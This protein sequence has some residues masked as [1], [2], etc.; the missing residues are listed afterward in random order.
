M[1]LTRVEK[2]LLILDFAK[3]SIQNFWQKICG[4]KVLKASA[5]LAIFFLLS[6]IAV[7]SYKPQ[8]NSLPSCS[9]LGTG[10][11]PQ[12]GVNCLINCS[13]LDSTTTPLPGQNCLYFGRPLCNTITAPNIPQH[14]VNCADLIDLPLCSDIVTGPGISVKPGKNCV[15]LCSNSAYDNPSPL[16]HPDWIRSVDY[17]IFNRDCIRFCDSVEDGIV[18]EPGVN[19]AERKCHQLV[20]DVAPNPSVNCNIL[21]CNLLTPDELNKA[22]FDDSAKQYCDGAGLKCY[23]FTSSQLPYMRLRQ[24]NPTCIIH[25]CPPTTPTCGANDVLNITN[26]NAVDP[27]YSSIYSQYIYGG[28]DLSSNTFCTSLNC[29]PVAKTQY[30]CTSKI[31]ATKTQ[32]LGYE[33]G[34]ITSI[35]GDDT[36]K[37]LNPN[38]DAT[39]GGHICSGNYCYK[40]VDCNV[41]ANSQASECLVASNLASDN[42]GDNYDPFDSWF[43]RPKPMSKATNPATGILLEMQEDLCYTENQMI[44]QKWGF[45][46]VIDWGILGSWD[47]GWFQNSWTN[48]RSPGACNTN[49]DGDRGTG[50]TYMCG[51]S[52]LLYN[53]PSQDAVYFK[54]YAVTDFS[55]AVPKHKVTV[56]TRFKNTLSLDTCGKRECGISELFSDF[57]SQAC[58]GDVCRELVI[59]ETDETACSMSDGLS[60]GSPD[61]CSATFDDYLRVRAV[62]YNNKICAFFDSKG[63]LAYNNMFF[64]GTE[65]IDF[66]DDDEINPGLACANDPAGVVTT[67]EGITT[68]NCDGYNSNSH[69][70]FADRWRAL[71]RVHYVDD[72]RPAN[73]PLGLKGY[74][75]RSGRLYSAQTCPKVTLRIPPPDLYNIGTVSNSEK[76]FAPPVIIRN[77]TKRRGAEDAIIPAGQVYGKTDFHFPEMKVMFGA[78]VYKMSLGFG[79]TGYE[80]S[81]HS[82][83]CGGATDAACATSPSS[84]T[85]TTN[86]G[87]KDYEARLFVRKEFF[88]LGDNTPQFCLYRRIKDQ[89]GLEITPLKIGCV[90]RND[91]D[92]NNSMDRAAD[93]SLPVRRVIIYPDPANQYN[94]SKINLRFLDG[95]TN[96]I[97]NNCA[98]DDKCTAEISLANADYEKPTCIQGIDKNNLETERQ[99]ICVQRE[100]CSAIYIDC[101]QNEIDLNNAKSSGQSLDVF[102]SKRSQCNGNLVQKCNAKK[103]IVA[104]GG[105]IFNPIP[106]NAVADPNAYGWFNEICIVSGF[107]PKLKKVIAHNFGNGGLGKCFIDQTS[108][109]LTDGN[110]ATNCNDGGR[111]PNCLCAVAPKDYITNIGEVVRLQTPHEAGLCVDMP[112]PSSC[113]AIDYNPNPNPDATDPE[114]INKSLG[115]SIY[116]DLTGIYH[117]HKDR[118]N[119]NIS[120]F[121]EFVQALP[122]MND[123][124]GVCSGFWTYNKNSFGVVQYPLQNCLNN[125][126]VASWDSANVKNPCIRYSCPDVLTAGPDVFGIYQGGYGVLES[127]EAKGTSNGFATWY[128]YTKTNDFLETT[129]AVGC[130]PGFKPKGSVAIKSVNGVITGYSGGTLPTRSCDQMGNWLLP[131]NACERIYCPPINSTNTPNPSSAQD[132]SGWTKWFV[133]GGAYFDASPIG[134]MASRS[135]VRAQTESIAT[136]R[137][138]T[139]IGFYQAGSPPTRECDYLGN[140]KEVKNSCSTSCTAVSSDD[141]GSSLNNGF[142]KWNVIKQEAILYENCGYDGWNIHLAVGDIADITRY[143]ASSIQFTGGTKATL[144]AGLNFSGTSADL[145]SDNSCFNNVNGID[146]ND[147]VQSIKISS[148]SGSS[149]AG[150]F[151]GCVAGYVTNP[152]PPAVDANGSPLAP[153]IANNLSRAPEN[154]KRA[155]NAVNGSAY[156][157]W[158]G[159]SNP[160]IDQ[161]PGAEVDSRIGV[162][163]TTHPLKSSLNGTTNISW[164]ST[165]LGQYAYVTNWNGQE[166]LFNAVYFQ[167]TSLVP[168]TNG[169][170]LMRRFCNN[171]GKWSDPEPLC[172]TNDGQI[173][174]AKYF[175]ANSPAGYKNSIAVGGAET[176]RGYCVSD[177][178]WNSNHGTGA[179]PQKKCSY[180]DSNNHIDRVYLDFA[181]NTKDCELKTCPSYAGWTGTRGKISPANFSA[182]DPRFVAGSGQISGSC[183]NNAKNSDDKTVYTSL[184]AGGTLP[185]INCQADGTWS[186]P[187]DASCK[188]GCDVSGPGKR[189]VNKSGCGDGMWYTL[190]DMTLAHDQLFNM[191]AYNLCDD[192]CQSWSY[193]VKCNDGVASVLVDR[194]DVD[195]NYKCR[196]YS[197]A[198]NFSL[199]KSGSDI[200]FSGFRPG[201]GDDTWRCS[202]DCSP[203]G[204]KDCKGSSKYYVDK[205][206]NPL[207]VCMWS[208]D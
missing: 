126:G 77:V 28:Q 153:A 113:L 170:Y 176:V 40:T 2:I 82:E 111:A 45:H 46:W 206:N 42:G 169:Y 57:T 92:I 165:P 35:K 15:D 38:C 20:G 66:N 128:K 150:Q 114:Y 189:R 203:V 202:G 207:S 52:G 30:R 64:D 48:L 162:G 160:C 79:Y 188:Y 60:N 154:P 88:P 27:S 94:N 145:T 159:V 32:Q 116:N 200:N 172:S 190:Q 117:T 167:A 78:Q 141:E 146:F 164:K 51:T 163:V 122:G 11:V 98:G 134:T 31:D 112:T 86:V 149:L 50:Y 69:E 1:K 22:K 132:S 175:D 97:D 85:V 54:G 191:S 137:C 14:R 118:S 129:K 68:I 3:E 73:T 138:N 71:L 185:H 109:Y 161:C 87:G 181:N 83:V 91:P 33:V 81:D 194:Q 36:D 7:F 124:H 186:A 44:K 104:S 139:A 201:Y 136:G 4:T 25:N 184:A 171:N 197:D 59:D 62:K 195:W 16:D 179:A 67:A 10:I 76:L 41:A 106:P 21:P 123:V 148:A 143:D 96:N 12:N 49:H 183:L 72:N 107:Q 47:F 168:R 24:V 9:T 119:G 142:A 173:D 178:Y 135:M 8:A 180:A 133:N 187:S 99:Q 17:A 157:V 105:N 127:G 205:F 158:S 108:P 53:K 204:N 63:Q 152:Y 13:A 101:I 37:Y 56:C 39:G 102:L 6:L 147:K 144:F 182:T 196:I 26:Q 19:C 58:G 120:G 140:W 43:Y 155:C 177:R 208:N 90:K 93:N 75:D 100:E 156:S 166:S 151:A 5:C 89:N 130:L 193:V 61:G 131:I 84:L 80:D 198:N 199:V 74:I 29:K 23:N 70:G 110:P 103:G 115:K 192:G 65:T 125:N 95:G 174:N 121:A 55:G 18:P 34:D